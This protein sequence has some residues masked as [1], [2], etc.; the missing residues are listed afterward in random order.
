ML[1]E[2]QKFKKTTMKKIT[3]MLALALTVAV[4][5]PSCGKYEDGPGISLRT[6]KARMAGDWKL[7]SLNLVEVDTDASGDADNTTT[8]STD[9]STLTVTKVSTSGS[10]S[11]TTTATGTITMTLTIKKDGSYTSTTTTELVSVEDF[12]G[13]DLTTTENESSTESGT[14]NFT[15]GVGSSIGSKEQLVLRPNSSSTTTSSKTVDESGN[16]ITEDDPSTTSTTITGSEQ[17]YTIMKLKN[18][19]LK[20]TR[21]TSSAS[22]TDGNSGGSNTSTMTVEFKQ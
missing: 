13:I 5:A 8:A 21:E 6:K 4:I 22:T 2:N 12:F 3:R 20:L 17:I 11:T 19:E 1:L 7:A 14:W 16:T 15:G 9:G 18:K 10:S